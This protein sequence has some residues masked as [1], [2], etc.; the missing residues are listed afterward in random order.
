MQAEHD[1]HQVWHIGNAGGGNS[2]I[3][4]NWGHM[5]EHTEEG[6]GLTLADSIAGS[7][8]DA[9]LA[10]QMAANPPG[11]SLRSPGLTV[12]HSIPP[13]AHYPGA[14]LSL[15]QSDTSAGGARLAGASLFENSAEPT[16]SDAAA[17]AAAAVAAKNTAAGVGR[18]D[19][20]VGL[21]AQPV[22]AA[23]QPAGAP[24]G[25]DKIMAPP[26]L[27]AGVFAGVQP[28]ERVVSAGVQPPLPGSVQ[29]PQEVVAR[30]WRL[31]M[32]NNALATIFTPGC[33]GPLIPI[34]QAPAP[35]AEP[36]MTTLAAEVLSGESNI[37]V[38]S[39]A[40][41]KPGMRVLI[42][43]EQ[44]KIVE[45]GIS[46]GS[47]ALGIPRAKD[48][49][50]QGGARLNVDRPF[51]ELHRM[52]SILLAEVPYDCDEGIN[53]WRSSWS[54]Q[55]IVYCC[56][57]YNKGCEY[58]CSDISVGHWREDWAVEKQAWCC[59][60]KQVACTEAT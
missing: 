9:A 51:K 12:P 50:L 13:V 14:G 47:A 23:A 25:A 16:P 21:G 48:G 49:L 41:F 56:S 44:R 54:Q 43:R 28:P 1:P 32:Q 46:S 6:L 36:G 31:Q 42:G 17:A 39:D 29:D 15:F 2:F 22:G 27:P 3:T 59:D 20:S 58:D 33:C 5:L 35:K 37:M 24:A 19:G 40:G 60:N 26:A 8:E 53:N 57:F 30:G 11:A 18:N 4:S 52:G 34:N 38:A 7:Q 45:N 55:R 10:H